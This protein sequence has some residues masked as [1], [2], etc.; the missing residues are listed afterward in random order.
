MNKTKQLRIHTSIQ[1]H[2][3]NSNLPNIW[4]SPLWGFAKTLMLELP[5]FN[6]VCIDL[7]ATVSEPQIQLLWQEISQPSA[8]NQIAFRQGNR[9]IARLVQTQLV[10]IPH[11]LA[12]ATQGT[13]ESLNWQPMNRRQPSS[14]EIEVKVKATGLNF[15]DVLTVLDSNLGNTAELGLECAGEVVAVGE[16][17]THLQVGDA[18]FG[19]AKGSFADYVTVL[20][21]WF[22]L[23]PDNLTFEES[24]TITG[25]FLTAYYSLIHRGQLKAREKVL[26]HAASG[27][28]GLAAVQLAQS[29]GA[30]ILATASPAKWQFLQDLGIKW[31]MNSRTLDFAAEIREIT[32]G[33]GVDL[34]LNSLSGYFIPQ[35]LSVLQ[36][37]G[38]FAEIGKKEIW[39]AEAVKELKPNVDY[40]SMDLLEIAEHN[41][42]L[43]QSL[44]QNLL[45]QF[46]NGLLT[47]LP[48]Q[49]FSRQEIQTAFRTLQQAKHIGKI[50]IVHS[51]G[52]REQGI[53]NREQGTGNREQRRKVIKDAGNREQGT[54]NREQGTGNRQQ[55]RKVIKDAG[56]REQGI[57]NREQGTG[58]RQ[59]GR[60]VIKDAGNREQGIGNREQ[61]TGNR[62]QRR[63][64]IKDAGNREQ[65]TGNREQGTGNREQR[66]K[67]IKDAGNR[68]QGTGN[69]EQGRKVI[70][71]A[72]NREQGI[73]NREQGT[74][75]REQRSKVVKND[76]SYLITGGFGD[77]GLNLAQWLA[78]QGAQYII[79][80]GRNQPSSKV[81]STIQN[82]TDKNIHL[83]P[84]TFD[85]TEEEAVRTFFDTYGNHN[86]PPLKGIIHA[87]GVLEDA[88][89]SQITWPQ[90][91]QVIAPKIKGAWYLHQFSQKENLDFFVLFS[92]VASLFGSPGQGNYSA[93]NAFLESLANLR[94]QMKLPAISINWGAFLQ[95]GMAARQNI[96]LSIAGMG[97]ISPEQGW[98][99]LAQLLTT[100]LSQVGV[101]PMD[102]RVV[103]SLNSPFFEE[104]TSSEC[105]E[106]TLAIRERLNAL[107]YSDRQQTLTIYILSQVAKIIGLKDLEA[108]DTDLGFS[109]LGIDSLTS[110]EL[111]NRLQNTLDCSLPST[112]TLDYPTI[113]H[114]TSYLLEKLFPSDDLPSESL[115]SHSLE[116][117]DIDQLS[118][119]E[120]EALLLE[121]LAK[122]SDLSNLT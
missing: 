10:A 26:I 48:Y 120:A 87:A 101:T 115:P 51:T 80:V 7:E 37:W 98:Y 107:T 20:A 73:G 72:G 66:R 11:R 69:R 22:V 30:E 5:E 110:L 82:L 1:Q 99:I 111:R 14:G 75:N 4:S 52:N 113:N 63:K 6:C 41:S 74:G 85:V 35:S 109:E 77:L 117:T 70:K 19:L 106:D 81:I 95:I 50:V 40:F 21:D 71:D 43:I 100:S 25:A 24:A 28:V 68:E 60:K 27:G 114:L 36:D 93:A 92:S 64:V 104:F 38:R 16:G 112:F 59:Q 39:T 58:N 57:G 121:E 90:F 62:E 17:V 42:S 45:T 34:V 89:L 122:I 78:T 29:L 108:I 53:G 96:P 23:K 105:H 94:Q 86:F 3:I 54:G 67:V 88:T 76:G 15:R 32:E 47:P 31:I 97:R 12:I 118:E 91:E 33:K 55:G 8:E 56:N 13:I 49:V 103:N 65:G 84:L 61:G 102:W 2:P 18:V 79:L 83:L 116:T 46:N 44:L 119:A 9:Y